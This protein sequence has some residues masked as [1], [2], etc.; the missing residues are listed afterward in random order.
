M[1]LLRAWWILNG[2][3][4]DAVGKTMSSNYSRG[5]VDYAIIVEVVGVV[6]DVH[7]RSLRAEVVPMVFYMWP[8]GGR[9]G[10]RVSS[11]DVASLSAYFDDVWRETV[12]EIPMQIE[13][14]PGNQ[15]GQFKS[16]YNHGR[17]CFRNSDSKLSQFFQKQ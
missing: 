17:L 7:F 10:V 1:V 3:V 15:L 11:D 8:Q 9:M 13:T 14:G 6:E 16:F 5:G 12:P 4:Q 2:D